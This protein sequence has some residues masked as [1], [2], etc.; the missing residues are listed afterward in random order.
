MSL[1]NQEK[2]GFPLTIPEESSSSNV[3]N[4]EGERENFQFS[5]VECAREKM[6]FLLRLQTP[7]PQSALISCPIMEQ[8]PLKSLE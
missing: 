5:F 2:Q 8:L 6:N 3:H 4:V 1:L 7:N